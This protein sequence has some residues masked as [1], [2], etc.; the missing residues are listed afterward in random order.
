MIE[1][2]DTREEVALKPG[3]GALVEE[4]Q[5]VPVKVHRKVDVG[6]EV[7]GRGAWRADSERKS[8]PTPAV[9]QEIIGQVPFAGR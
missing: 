2:R 5:S 9:P 4:W 3:Q 6:Y 7:S 1:G 8:L